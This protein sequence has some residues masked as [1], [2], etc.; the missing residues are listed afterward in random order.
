MQEPGPQELGQE[1]PGLMSGVE[2]PWDWPR[3]GRGG[4]G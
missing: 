2:G 4:G 1:G 3:L